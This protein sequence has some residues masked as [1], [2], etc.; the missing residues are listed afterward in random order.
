MVR[1]FRAT[2]C[3]RLTLTGLGL[4]VL[5]PTAETAAQT[6][7]TFTKVVD[8]D[9]PVPGGT[10]HFA[11]FR[12]I[13]LDGGDIAFYG[14]RVSLPN[15][16]RGIYLASILGALNVVADL[17]TP[18]PGGGGTFIGFQSLDLDAGEVAFHG[19]GVSQSGVYR[20][21][22]PSALS[23]VADPNTPIPG[24]TGNFAGGTEPS[25][26]G[27]EVA[28]IG[29]GLSNQFGVYRGSGPST[30]TVVADTNTPIP[31]GSGSFSSFRFPSLRGGEVAFRG[32]GALGQT[33]IYRRTGPSTP[34]VVVDFNTPVPGGSGNFDFIFGDHRYVPSLDNGQIVFLGGA[35]IS[36]QS[37]VYR[38][39]GPTALNVV[40][41]RNTPVPGG[42][43][44][45]VDFIGASSDGGEVAFTAFDQNDTGVFTTLGG[46]PLQKVIGRGDVLDGRT[47]GG[48]FEPPSISGNQVAF[49]AQFSSGGYGIFIAT[50]VDDQ[51][52]DGIPDADDNCPTVANSDQLDANGD[53]YGDAC[54]AS[55]VP[56][57][58][59][60]GGN[61]I[62][63]ANV[64]ISPGVSFGDDAEI[65]AGARLDR[66]IIAGD[67]VS[68]GAGSKLSQGITIGDAVAIGPNVVIGQGTIIE[69]GVRIGLACLPPASATSPP[70][71]Q[72][73]R[74]GRLRTNAVIQQNVT[75]N[76]GVTVNTG[77]TV[78]A[79]SNVKKG[80]VVRC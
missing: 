24:G 51:D 56:P 69:N 10:G 80:A 17:N 49:V 65:G 75:L 30:L 78:A 11:G 33:G 29:T 4:I 73:G 1:W 64:Q 7:F 41:D 34:T 21:S 76:Q 36:A 15:V 57:G 35:D 26:D 8:T 63:G 79:G 61:P 27:G 44:N 60:F 68:V 47:I 5:L 46:G 71:V 14:E 28:F 67:D 42:S 58:T 9:T 43:G 32:E 37:G 25:L 39:S 12:D 72:I 70:C 2:I 45:F 40:A 20:G 50:L 16:E 13:S 54:V 66:S 38:G 22:G 74:D 48:I 53:G 6:Q 18:I 52:S 77:C 31:N 23:V 59:D 55:T 19:I 3:L 62:I